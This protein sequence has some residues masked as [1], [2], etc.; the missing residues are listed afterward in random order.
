MHKQRKITVA[1]AGQPNCGKST[2]F[3]ALTGSTARVGNYPGITVERMEGYCKTDNY[4]IKFI[5]LPGTYSLTSYSMEEVVARDVI[6]NE[7]PDVVVC[8]LDSAALE[9]SLYLV[10][11]L[12]EIGI[13]VIVGLNMM[14]EIK[15]K[16]IQLNSS[17]LSK[18]LG[19]PVIECVARR[20]IGKLE[21]VNEIIKT[22]ENINKNKPELNISYSSDLDSALDKM[23][24]LIVKN[25]FLTD[26]YP[27]RWLAIKYMEQDNEIIEKGRKEKTISEE[28]EKIVAKVEEH[29]EKT[30]N[31]Y[32]E[33]IIADYRYGYIRSLLKE[34]VI[35]R[36]Q[37][38]RRTFSE[39]VDKIIT[40]RLLGPIIMVC[41]LYVLFWLTFTVGAYPQGWLQDFFNLLGNLGNAYI[42]NEFLRSL[43]VS[44]IIDGVGAVLSF[45][46][47]ILIM[48]A[49]LCYL[50]DLGYMAR[51]A[52]MLDKLFKMFGL[53][54]ASVMPFIVSG[55]IPG[56]CA[57]P[58]VMTTRT[59]KSP[60]ERLATILTAPFMVC[61]AKTTV[62][63]MFADAFFKN[64][65]TLVM[66]GLT[67]AA[68]FFALVVAVV[69]RST[70]IKGEP[71]PFIM[72]LPPYRL[73]TMYG[74]ITHT[75]DRVWQFIKKAGTVIFAVAIIMW[76]LMTFPQLPANKKQEFNIQKESLKSQYVT[77]TTKSS[78]STEKL[79][80]YQIKL[81]DLNNFEEQ[82]A[83]K[84]SIGG[85]LGVWF[86][87]ISK[88]AGFPW[89]ANIA[90]IGGFAA[91]EVIL[92]T[93]STAYSLG[94]FDPDAAPPAQQ[95][96]NSASKLI[97]STHS[98]SS[99]LE[100]S[101][102]N[103]PAWT[104]PAIISLFLFILLY[105]PC[106]VTV[107]T[108]A[109]EATWKWAIGGT[110]G[111]LIFAYILSVIVFQVGTY[112]FM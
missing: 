22:S 72:E 71:T 12:I 106:M 95:G 8:M 59:L 26:I 83:L 65:A 17:K 108:M 86:E 67:I 31:T 92:S 112:I 75:W 3:N 58:G 29:T 81:H 100:Q 99:T 93:M 74:I 10:I 37:E 64:Q 94:D 24:D 50:E 57:V 49:M 5:D 14:D 97:A 60:K 52:Y 39:K 104:T 87:N 13:P 84:H 25:N 61:G 20:N 40:Q 28:L 15:R 98:S 44:G 62:Y 69:L 73:P 54:G 55:G 53:H 23:E 82:T 63:L 88:Y 70:I 34:G 90:L 43:I 46:P 110:I 48:F 35:E 102:R 51:V 6:L 103:D 19:V 38:F 107:V 56:G 78:L 32:P 30:L 68:W 1:L 101:L 45:A 4:K 105:A 27:P 77:N 79:Q 18:L 7:K 21:I 42:H 109:K 66:L 33:A 91:K 16:G 80:E 76:V 9:R 41:V 36:T 11:Q 85:R 2:M 111:S 47:L 89:Q 96:N